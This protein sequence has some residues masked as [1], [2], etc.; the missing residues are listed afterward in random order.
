VVDYIA[1][2]ASN[3]DRRWHYEEDPGVY[4][5]SPQQQGLEQESP[6]GARTRSFDTLAGVTGPS[7]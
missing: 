2:L 1:G 3:P 7:R 4:A 5:V 6:D